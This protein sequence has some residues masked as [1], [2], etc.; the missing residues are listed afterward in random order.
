MIRTE[1][2]CYPMIKSRHNARICWVNC[3]TA[4]KSSIAGANSS[5]KGSVSEIGGVNIP[6]EP[7]SRKSC[8]KIGGIFCALFVHE[9]CRKQEGAAEEQGTV[10][11]ALFCTLCNA[12]V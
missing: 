1:F 6:S 12:E 4:S 2:I 11:D 10:E 8:S 3:G 7:T 5:K 9:D